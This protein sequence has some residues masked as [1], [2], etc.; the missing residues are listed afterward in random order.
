[1]LLYALLG[2]LLGQ[3]HLLRPELVGLA[4]VVGM[5]NAVL[6]PV[7]VRVM[8]WVLSGEREQAFAR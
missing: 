3:A 4:A 7:V 5:L 6:V 1:V 8:S 2:S